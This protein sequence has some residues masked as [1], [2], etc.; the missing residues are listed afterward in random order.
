MPNFDVMATSVE[1]LVPKQRYEFRLRNANAPNNLGVPTSL[2]GKD[3][4]FER[5]EIRNGRTIP[6]FSGTSDDYLAQAWDHDPVGVP[7]DP[8]MYKFHAEIEEINVNYNNQSEVNLNFN[9]YPTAPNFY[10]NVNGYQAPAP[11]PV[12]PAINF[13]AH[14]NVNPNKPILTRRRSNLGIDPITQDEFEDGENVV[15]FKGRNLYKREGLRSWLANHNTNPVNNEKI[16]NANNLKQYSI[17]I[18]GGYRR[19]R[20]TI[21]NKSR[22]RSRTNKNK[23]RR[24]S[25]KS[26]RNRR[27]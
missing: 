27:S 9:G 8:I 1:D 10:E 24:S 21:K 26:R 2:N 25:N 23:S 15:L 12:P 11:V 7:I 19:R 6:Y 5:N 20:R 22:R 17:A 13:Q 4:I 18:N 14:L 3:A 16:T